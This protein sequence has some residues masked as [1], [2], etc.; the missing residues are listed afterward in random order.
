MRIVPLTLKAAREFVAEHHRHNKKATGHK[1]SIG[2]MDGDRLV[3]VA[4]AGRP[5]SRHL[6]DGLTIEVNRTCTDGTPNANSM[7][8]GAIWRAAKGMGYTK[9]VTYTQA[10]ETGASL[11]AAGWLPV[12]VLAA[13]KGWAESSGPRFKARRDLVGSGG[14]QRI[15]WEVSTRP[16]ENAR[17]V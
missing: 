16:K 7:L 2:L 6:D 17:E 3:G 10:E 13:R 9:A 15:R 4:I 8:Y 11:R 5:I 14:V 1:F 12:K